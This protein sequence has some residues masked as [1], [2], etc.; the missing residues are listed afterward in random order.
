MKPR[1]L[2]RACRRF[3]R[4]EDGGVMI[5][6]ILWFPVFFSLF[7]MVAD[8][9]VIFLNQ[10]RIKKIMQDGSRAMAVGTYEECADLTA[11]LNTEIR[12]IAPNAWVA[13]CSED[14]TE[15]LV[16]VSAPSGDLGLTGSSGLFG[17]FTVSLRMIYHL[18]VG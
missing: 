8:A 17:G 5:E 7:V 1:I 18:E 9:S 12:R 16:L 14:A 3:R 4:E 13:D 11:F 2:T 6:A 10:A 15:S